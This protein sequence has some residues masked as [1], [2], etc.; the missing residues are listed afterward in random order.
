[1]LDTTLKTALPM[2]TRTRE[3]AKG[4]FAALI[5]A[6]AARFLSEHY[7][8]PAMLMALLLGIAFHF[9]HEDE[10]CRPGIEFT[11]RTV[12]RFGVAL[13]GL[14][15]SWQ[16]LADLGAVSIFWIAFG[17]ASTI[18]IGLAGAAVLRLGWRFGVLTG[19]S[20]AI[21]G[22]SAAMAIAAVLPRDDRSD[23]NLIFTVIG[24]TLLSTLAMILYPIVTQFTGMDSSQAGLFL[25]STIHDVAQVVGAGYS[26]SDETGDVATVVKLLRVTLLAPVIFLISLAVARSGQTAG[27]GKRPPLMPMF[28]VGFFILAAVNSTVSLPH[29][30]LAVASEVSRWMLLTAVAAVGMKTSL[31]QLIEVGGFAILLIVAETLYLALGALLLIIGAA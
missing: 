17:V 15:I 29:A 13:L 28:V 18:A 12:L 23:T 24:V 9:L 20:V 1:M 26:V 31:K 4:V 14:R 30:M 11:A 8:A 5:V 3:L 2:A 25:G 7:G 19:G 10:R 27:Q 22:A 21:C 16:M 6:C